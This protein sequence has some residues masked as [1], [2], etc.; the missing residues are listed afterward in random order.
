MHRTETLLCSGNS[1][2]IAANFCLQSA[3]YKEEP[4]P[5]GL[6]T[7][8][9]EFHDNE[10][11]GAGQEPPKK[12]PKLSYTQSLTPPDSDVSGQESKVASLKRVND[13]LREKS[14][15]RYVLS[16]PEDFFTL[17]RVDMLMVSCG[18]A[19]CRQY[20]VIYGA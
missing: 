13:R 6:T 17:A 5:T 14:R 2:D 1:W 8:F 3:N 16:R 9:D 7:I 18:K 11:T 15:A 10:P 20:R 4:V 12:R 19:A